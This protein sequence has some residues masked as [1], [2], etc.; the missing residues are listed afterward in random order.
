M[1]VNTILCSCTVLE[2]PPF[3]HRVTAHVRNRGQSIHHLTSLHH[4]DTAGRY[5]GYITFKTSERKAFFFCF[6]E[7]LEDKKKALCS[8]KYSP[9]VPDMFSEMIIF[10]GIIDHAAQQYNLFHL[11]SLSALQFICRGTILVGKK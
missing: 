5:R 6:V 10:R 3:Y 4:D 1:Y 9:R 8:K 11:T 2:F 7:W